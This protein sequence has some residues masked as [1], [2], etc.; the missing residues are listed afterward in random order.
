MKDPPK[1]GLLT[2]GVFIAIDA[3]TTV[4]YQ[5]I[6]NIANMAMAISPFIDNRAP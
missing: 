5:S 2:L 4:M 6:P 3:S 1:Q